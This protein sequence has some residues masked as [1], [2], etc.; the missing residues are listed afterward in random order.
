MRELGIKNQSI[1]ESAFL[2][3]YGDSDQGSL[4]VETAKLSQSFFDELQNHAAPPRRCCDP[5]NKQQLYRTRYLCVAC[6][7]PTRTQGSYTGQLD[8]AKNAV[9]LQFWSD[10]SL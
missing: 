5:R 7:S 10:E 3:D 8:S 6:F 1:V 2:L 9:W 4:F